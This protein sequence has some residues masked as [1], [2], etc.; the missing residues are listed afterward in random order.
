MA[1]SRPQVIALIALTLCVGGN[2]TTR[3]PGAPVAQAAP[4]ELVSELGPVVERA[5]QRFVVFWS[6]L[7]PG[8]N[9]TWVIVG[10]HESRNACEQV[11]NARLDGDRLVC[12]SISR[13][14]S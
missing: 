5:R 4:P 3:V 12:A 11:R 10:G 9:W 6:L 13:P 1:T 8:E 2:P 7:A 14:T